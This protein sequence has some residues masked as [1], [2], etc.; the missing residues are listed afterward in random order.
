MP[1]VKVPQAKGEIRIF[2][3]GYVWQVKDHIAEVKEEDLG[4]FLRST[5]GKVVESKSDSDGK[6]S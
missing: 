3:G 6:E 2:P 5:E 1:K 4:L